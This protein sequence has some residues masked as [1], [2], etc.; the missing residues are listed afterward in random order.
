MALTE[1]LKF[2]YNMSFHIKLDDDAGSRY[3]LRHC[4]MTNFRLSKPLVQLILAA[5]TQEFNSPYTNAIHCCLNLNL[6]PVKSQLFPDDSPTQVVQQLVE[7]LDKQIPGDTESI[8]DSSLDENLSPVV[9]LLNN[10]QEVAPDQV[11]TYLK[12]TLMPSES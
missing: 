5:S 7:I 9:I 8:H 11:K 3:I 12:T 4:A 2:L 1:L 6:E 10:I